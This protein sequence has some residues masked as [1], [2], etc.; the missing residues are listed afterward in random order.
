MFQRTQLKR[1]TFLHYDDFIDLKDSGCS[2]SKELLPRSQTV[3]G[4]VKLKKNFF[5]RVIGGERLEGEAAQEVPRS[6]WCSGTS[7]QRRD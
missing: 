3:C 7:C 6:V 2:V 5:G 1:K 4:L